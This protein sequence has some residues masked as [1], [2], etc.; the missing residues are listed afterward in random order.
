M[1]SQTTPGARRECRPFTDLREFLSVVKEMGQLKVVEGADWDLE[2]GALTGMIGAQRNC[3]VLLFDSIKGYSRG[4]RMMTN[5]LNN[6]ARQRLI[7]GCPPEVKDSEA[8]QWWRAQLKNYQSVPPVFVND[9]PVKQN[10]KKGDDVNLKEFPWI[11][12]H[13]KDGGPYMCAT[14]TV[15]RELET[16]Y[17]NVGSYRFELVDRNTMVGHLASGHHGDIIRK[18][19]WARGKACPVAISLGQELSI[20]VAAGDAT[21][22]G[23]SEYDYAGWLRGAP[24]EVTSGVFTDLPIPAT[25]E[26]VLEGELLPPQA[27]VATEGPFGEMGG[28]YGDASPTPLVRINAVLH[29]DDPIIL[30]SPPFPNTARNLFGARGLRVW[31]ELEAL[32]IPGIKGIRFGG[33]VLIIS[34]DQSFPGHAMRAALGALGGTGGYH[35]RFVILVDEDVDPHNLN[36][37][38]SAMGTRC[39]PDTSLDITRRMWSSRVDARLEP[40]KIEKGDYTSSVAIIDATRPYYWRDHFPEKVRISPELR[41]AMETKWHE[42]LDVEKSN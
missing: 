31:A 8:V 28:Y 23:N 4:F 24:V 6:G 20:L 10:V 3:P 37:V 5:M 36:E 32:G 12:W 16:G 14:S 25:A 19:Y 13:E 40:E 22:W 34:I 2:I 26:V 27:G 41:R 17:I 29:R 33:G 30:G 1:T 18:K 38:L 7:Y 9:A 42:L 11:R 21:T 15:T 35:T 39:D